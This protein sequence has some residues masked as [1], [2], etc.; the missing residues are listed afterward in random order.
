MLFRSSLDRQIM[1]PLHRASSGGKLE[2]MRCLLDHGANINARAVDGRT[3]LHCAIM[4]SNVQAARFLLERGA[5]VNACDNDG[6]TPS[7][8]AEEQEV[9]E[10]L[11]EY[12]T[13]SVVLV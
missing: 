13:M 6:N 8:L 9:V 4:Y 11:S 1:T 7:H 10:L 12:R 2:A 3:P 5:D